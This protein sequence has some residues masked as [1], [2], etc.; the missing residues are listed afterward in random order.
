V[1]Q[2]VTTHPGQKRPLKGHRTK[3]AQDELDGSHGLKR[4][5]C[6]KPVKA[7]C[8]T[9]HCEQIHTDQE[10]EIEPAK[11]PTPQQN[12]GGD[13]ANKRNSHAYEGSQPGEYAPAEGI[14]LMEI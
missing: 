3:D 11:S 12:S 2:T 10:T 5:V 8:H 14:F 7:N 13:H 4:A 9:N 1:V 6:E